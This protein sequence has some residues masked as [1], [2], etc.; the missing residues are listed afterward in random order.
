RRDMMLIPKR[1]DM[2]V[3]D[4][5]QGIGSE[6]ANERPVVIIQ[7]NKGNHYADTTIIVPITSQM[8]AQLPN[9]VIIHYGILT[10]YQG[11]V[12]TEQIRTISVLRLKKYIGRLSEKDIRRIEKALRIS[13]DMDN[14]GL[15]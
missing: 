7:N 2:Y 4:L 10:K 5:G 3:A 9:H 1:G 13:L 14:K 12:L 8:K 11:C 6:Q 15:K